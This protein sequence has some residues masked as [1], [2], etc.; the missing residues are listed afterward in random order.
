MPRKR[1][2]KSEKSNKKIQKWKNQGS[3]S[4]ASTNPE[5]RLPQK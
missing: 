3:K 2:K 5:R 4:G 1:T